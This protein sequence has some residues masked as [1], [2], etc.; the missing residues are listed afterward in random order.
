V[1]LVAVA[2]RESLLR[3]HGFRLRREDLEDCYSQATLELILRARRDGAFADSSHVV[4]ALEQRFLSRVMD[5]RRAI[6][7]RSPMQAALE[8]ASALDMG[9]RL[10]LADRRTPV[11]QVVILRH[12]LRRIRALAA[13]L[14]EDQRLVLANQ[15]AAVPR[16]DF[17]ARHGW[18]V[19]KYRKV[20]QR[21]RAR[22][23]LLMAREEAVPP[24]G[25]PSEKDGG[26]VPMIA[27]TPAGGR[28]PGAAARRPPA[29]A[30]KATRS[31]RTAGERAGGG[32]SA[33]ERGRG[34]G[35]FPLPS[36]AARVEAS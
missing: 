3:V 13:L 31:G 8:G 23:R 25:Q 17:C 14:T 5:R 27:S 32:P 33:R 4:N 22:L 36:P 20:A 2:R 6:A 16:A 21:A 12:D 10:Q 15:L 7:G 26:V 28:G 30:G 18:T 24:A 1:A 9:A 35:R 19:D 29:P 34:P 11:E